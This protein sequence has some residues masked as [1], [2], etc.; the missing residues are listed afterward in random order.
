MAE[1]SVFMDPVAETAFLSI[2][3][4]TGMFLFMDLLTEMLYSCL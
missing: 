2:E 3:L 1:I 4:D